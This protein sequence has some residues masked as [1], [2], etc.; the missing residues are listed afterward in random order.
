MLPTVFQK[1]IVCCDEMFTRKNTIEQCLGWT[2]PVY[3][4]FVYVKKVL[5]I[6][7]ETSCGSSYGVLRKIL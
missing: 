7:I 2:C 4:N 1:G 5:T 6:S 3:V